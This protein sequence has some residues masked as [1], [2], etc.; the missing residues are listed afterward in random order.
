MGQ[1]LVLVTFGGGIVVV[2]RW[3]WSYWVL[4]VAVVLCGYGGVHTVEVVVICKDMISVAVAL[5]KFHK[6][7]SL[8]FL[9]GSC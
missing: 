9:V 5:K 8:S 3:G 1:V 7:K 2:S 6:F 4:A